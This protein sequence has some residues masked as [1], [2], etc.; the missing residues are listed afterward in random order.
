MVVEEIGTILIIPSGIM[1]ILGIFMNFWCIENYYEKLRKFFELIE[2]FGMVL[3]FVAIGLI[4][5]HDL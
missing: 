2:I 5:Y 4:M 3:F 1:V